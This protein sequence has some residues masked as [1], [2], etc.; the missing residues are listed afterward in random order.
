MAR[1]HGKGYAEI[2]KIYLVVSHQRPQRFI[3]FVEDGAPYRVP[4][5][6]LALS[7][8]IL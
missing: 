3:T 2:N 6:A 5:H 8:T 1:L 4:S 7:A